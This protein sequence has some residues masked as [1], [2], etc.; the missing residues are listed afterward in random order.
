MRTP[1]AALGSGTLVA[2]AIAWQLAQPALV[3]RAERPFEGHG[4][5]D[6]RIGGA[7]YPRRAIGADNEETAVAAPPARLV[8]QFSS[9]DELL[10]AVVPPAR[11]VGVS[12]NAYRA[13]SSNVHELAAR[14]RPAIA[15]DPERVL[16]SDPDLVFTPAEMRSDVP[17][18]LRAAGLPVYR[19]HTMFPTLASIEAH[20]RLVGYLTGEDARADAEARRFAESIARAAARRPA[21]LRRPRVM[22]FGGSYSY[23]AETLFHDILRVLGAE[24]VA[25]THGFAGYDRVSDEHIVRWDPEWIVA[26]ADRG[27]ADRVRQR[28][29][30]SP[31]IAAT[32]AGRRRQVVVFENHVFLPLS[33]FTSRFVEALADALYGAQS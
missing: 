23:G 20:I 15:L 10:Y 26:G 13:S 2:A 17:G 32:T 22:G 7:A 31:A 33:P 3:R 5:A 4:R 21:D 18:L 28:L 24:N 14:F 6:V 19:I 12:E 11:V 30:A 9:T 8:S 1:L 25:A 27:Q 16:L 29:L